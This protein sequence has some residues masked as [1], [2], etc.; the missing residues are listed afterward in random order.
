MAADFH[1]FISFAIMCTST[2][3]VSTVVI[4]STTNLATNITSSAGG[5]YFRSLSLWSDALSVCQ[6][7]IATALVRGCVHLACLALLV[8]QTAS[9]MGWHSP[10]TCC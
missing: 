9:P 10:R 2:A 1:A 7:Q 6:A 8:V 5:F 3:G 4:G